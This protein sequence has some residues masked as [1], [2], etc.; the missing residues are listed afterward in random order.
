MWFSF[1]NALL[2]L[3]PYWNSDSNIS[4]ITAST[5]PCFFSSFSCC[6][7]LIT[8]FFSHFVLISF[9]FFLFFFT[10]FLKKS[11][12][13][14]QLSIFEDY[15]WLNLTKPTIGHFGRSTLYIQ[16]CS[17]IAIPIERKGSMAQVF[18]GGFCQ[19]G[20]HILL[21]RLSRVFSILY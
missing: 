11:G 2:K 21:Q 10:D 19:I 6:F 13:W 12:I 3:G 18:D 4:R 14:F 5:R 1:A 16:D 9:L 15:M 7:F 8:F 20:S 17:N